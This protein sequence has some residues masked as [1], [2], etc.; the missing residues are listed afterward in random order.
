MP[1]VTNPAT[2]GGT[3]AAT[4]QYQKASVNAFS[5]TYGTSKYKISC[6][7]YFIPVIMVTP[8]DEHHS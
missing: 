2:H 4:A 5:H 7:Y 6:N 3:Q 8:E 1:S